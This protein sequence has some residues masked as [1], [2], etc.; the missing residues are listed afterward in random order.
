MH[1]QF[2]SSAGGGIAIAHRPANQFL[3][4]AL[5]RTRSDLGLGEKPSSF[6][7]PASANSAACV[8]HLLPVRRQARD[9]FTGAAHIFVVTSV[10]TPKAPPAHILSGLFDLS[11]AES[12]VA[13][14]IVEGGSVE[15]IATAGNL[16]RETVRNQIKS[17]LAKT[18]TSRQA[19]LVGLLLG[20]QI[21]PHK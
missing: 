12:R 14:K 20:A 6:A 3:V 15:E 13:Q 18:G 2:L 8:A 19:E 16:S 4:E 11:P 1:E 9:I 7:F 17:V 5:S 10:S 21:K